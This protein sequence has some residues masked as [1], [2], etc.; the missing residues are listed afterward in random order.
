MDWKILWTTFGLV[1]LAELGD[2]T[3]LATLNFA[4]AGRHPLSVFVGAALALVATTA[5][6]VALGSAAQAWLPRQWLRIGAGTLFI[7]AGVIILL[8]RG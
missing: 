8:N 6:A 5:V 3:Q 1:F 7:G 4:A 2:K